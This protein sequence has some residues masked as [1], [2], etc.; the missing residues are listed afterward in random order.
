MSNIKNKS[1]KSL[2]AQSFEV[3]VINDPEMRPFLNV[4]EAE[5]K[6]IQ[7]Q[8]LGKV[9]GIIQVDDNTEN[10]AYL[11]NLL[12]QVF[13]KEYYK[14][15]NK[16]CGQSFEIALH[17]MNLTL[18][19]LAQH[20]IV[21]WINNLNA[22]VGVICGK[23]I[24]FAQIGKGVI[25]FLKDKKIIKIDADNSN[26][27]D[28]HP[29]KTFSSISAG[30][31]KNGD[32]IIFT[33]KETFK[34]LKDDELERHFKTFNSD[35]F[36]NIISSTLRNEASNTGMLVINI[37]EDTGTA[38]ENSVT[39]EPAIEEDFNFFGKNKPEKEKNELLKTP[40]V[41]IEKEFNNN[42]NIK[43]EKSEKT[44]EKKSN[45]KTE[46]PRSPFEQEPEIFLKED[47]IEQEVDENLEKN[48]INLNLS[49]EKYQK[50]LLFLKEIFQKWLGKTSIK[51]IS[52]NKVK[53]DKLQKDFNQN[54][55]K[56][57][58]SKLF[59]KFKKGFSNINWKKNKDILLGFWFKTKEFS[60]KTTKTSVSFIS[61]KFSGKN[62]NEIKD[63]KI[64][65][66]SHQDPSD[67]PATKK[68]DKKER[69]ISIIQKFYQKTLNLFR[70]W[71]IKV[72]ER[73]SS[74]DNKKKMILTFSIIFI[75]VVLIL[76]G[77]LLNR[78]PSD[79]SQMVISS[80]N[81]ITLPVEEE[82]EISSLTNL[83]ALNKKIRDSVFLNNDLFLLTEED[84]LIKYSVRD[85][86]KTEILLPDNFEDG[87]Y[88]SPVESLQLVL[89]VSSDQV[90]SYSPVTN[91]FSENSIVLPQNF[92]NIGVGTYLTYLYLLDK[93][94]KQIYRYYRAAGGF[95]EFKEW[96]K[97]KQNMNQVTAFDVS[98]SIYLSFED[99]RLEKYFQGEKTKS[100][101]LGEDFYPNKIRAKINKEEVFALD[102]KRGIIIKL[103][104]NQNQQNLFEDK[105]FED[106]QTFAVD[107]E[108]KKIYLVNKKDELLV[109]S[110]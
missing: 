85:N 56:K 50:K 14:N 110:Y 42:Q 100:F 95:G 102:S 107:F 57:S 55:N 104:E 8:K 12:T 6:N 22:V 81:Q 73:F 31:I 15:K 21:K 23:E 67:L 82:K 54:F 77:W 96:L 79:S 80:E 71:G 13:K 32:K 70:F 109:F 91:K 92:E 16:S 105:N 51:K 98:D 29:M 17:K 11:P 41:K 63:K 33:I 40:K 89:I 72:K 44:S 37:K 66:F 99:G 5:G 88:L 25:L 19:E 94:N 58:A 36:D 43:K 45:P 27:E 101:N 30:K 35:E 24:H 60:K 10:S 90:L 26:S 97:E 3:S 103:L 48:G 61:N 39:P 7:Q 20:E 86:N 46:K 1:K 49:K 83:I 69:I 62:N 34:T 47:E 28:Y 2:E 9:F 106:A 68:N 84:S 59:D 4:F 76:T 52:F 78:K 93:N 74:L 64:I 108:D 18:T 75:I 87:L 38:L 65:S 53:I